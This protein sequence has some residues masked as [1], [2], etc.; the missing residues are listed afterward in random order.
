VPAELLR[1]GFAAFVLVMGVFVL[2]QQV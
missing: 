1:K 2:A